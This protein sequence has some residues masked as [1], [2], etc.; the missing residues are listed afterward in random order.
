MATKGEKKKKNDNKTDR[1]NKA[2]V[3]SAARRLQ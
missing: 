1:V 3:C 2:R